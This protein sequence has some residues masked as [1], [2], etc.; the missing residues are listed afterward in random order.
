MQSCTEGHTW[1]E[2]K[3]NLVRFGRIC[4]P[5]GANDQAASD[6]RDMKVVLP[7]IGPVLFVDRARLQFANEVRAQARQVP[8]SLFYALA[9]LLFLAIKRKI[10][11]HVHRLTLEN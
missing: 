4:A 11:A 2:G 5:G 7:G 6:M 8:E 3:H 1:I 9:R 10:G